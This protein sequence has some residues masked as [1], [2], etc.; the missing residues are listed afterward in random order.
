MILSRVPTHQ[1]PILALE[2][3][4]ILSRV[5]THQ[6]PILALEYPMILSRVPHSPRSNISI[7]ISNDT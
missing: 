5:P 1:D 2:Y 4:M 7:R 3:P 6:D